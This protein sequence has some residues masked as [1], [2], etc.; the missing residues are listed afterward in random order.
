MNSFLKNIKVKRKCLFLQ[1][2]VFGTIG[3]KPPKTKH[4]ETF[5][6]LFKKETVQF[7]WYKT[8]VNKVAAFKFKS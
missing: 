2:Q 3:K 1:R 7:Y 8:K 5:I 6:N 4:S